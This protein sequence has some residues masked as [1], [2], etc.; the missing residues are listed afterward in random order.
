MC[1]GIDPDTKTKIENIA[2]QYSEKVIM[3]PRA[4]NDAKIVLVSWGQSEKLNVYNEKAIVE[5]ITTNKNKS[6]EPNAQ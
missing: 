5:F 2:K 6:P 1:S 3:T 4:K